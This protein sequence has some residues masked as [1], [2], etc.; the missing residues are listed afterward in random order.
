MST[1]L[2]I[3]DATLSGETLQQWSLDVLTERV[4]VRELIRSRVYQEVQDYNRR[5]PARFQGLIQPGD[6]ERALN[7][8]KPAGPR[9]IDWRR[10]FDRALTAF[11]KQQI[12]IFVH[13]R[14][15]E[16]L[17]EQIVI[18]PGAEVSFLRL[19]MLTGG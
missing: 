13:D 14:Q 19:T 8:P 12:L 4:T 11:G 3:R 16:D 18:T 6:D 15:V 2:T 10:Q 7:G 5:Q 1:T 9:Q 17:E